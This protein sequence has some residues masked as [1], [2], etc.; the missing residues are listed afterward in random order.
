MTRQVRLALSFSGESINPLAV[1]IDI[2]ILCRTFREIQFGGLGDTLGAH[3]HSTPKDVG[4]LLDIV[5]KEVKPSTKDWE[6]PNGFGMILWA[7]HAY[8]A[9]GALEAIVSTFKLTPTQCRE[10]I[11][12][13]DGLLS[14]TREEILGPGDYMRT[15]ANAVIQAAFRAVRILYI[16][17]ELPEQ[18]R[19]ARWICQ[20]PNP[21]VAEA[22][23]GIP[24]LGEV[25]E[26]L[27][28]Q[29]K[30]VQPKR[31]RPGLSKAG[32]YAR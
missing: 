31:N 27:Q 20:H 8:D 3:A 10:L 13:L 29:Q 6:S 24:G 4:R 1:F 15:K 26:R 9:M 18:M 28:V 5:L 14:D 7:R 25:R 21:R 2:R 16:Q 17:S 32:V 23:R 19:I 12:K 22:L 30:L 11:E